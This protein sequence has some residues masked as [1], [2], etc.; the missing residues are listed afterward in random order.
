MKDVFN[1]MRMSL[2]I[3]MY[4]GTHEGMSRVLFRQIERR[5]GRVS[6]TIRQR[7]EEMTDFEELDH[8]ADRVLEVENFKQLKQLINSSSG[9]VIMEERNNPRKKRTVKTSH[10]LSRQAD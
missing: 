9:W 4:L 8:I 6:S 3:G 7:I 5:F 1:Y 2:E 10:A